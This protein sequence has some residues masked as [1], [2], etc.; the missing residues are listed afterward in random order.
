MMKHDPNSAEQPTD[1]ELR[2]GLGFG[3]IPASA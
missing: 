1:A 3:S 2:C